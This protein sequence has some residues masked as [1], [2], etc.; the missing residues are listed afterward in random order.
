MKLLF[1]GGFKMNNTK[2]VFL[3]FYISQLIFLLYSVYFLISILGVVLLLW[4]MDPC[5]SIM[6]HGN[7]YI[8]YYG[9]QY[10]QNT[11]ELILFFVLCVGLPS[12]YNIA[13]KIIMLR[14]SRKVYKQTKKRVELNEFDNDSLITPCISKKIIRINK[15]IVVV[16]AVLTIV[17]HIVCTYNS[18]IF[19]FLNVSSLILTIPTIIG[20]L[21]FNHYIRKLDKF[22]SFDVSS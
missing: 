14:N 8:Y 12:L 9:L 22:T 17:F 10:Y 4:D 1:Q 7:E 20:I 18:Y 5:M 3:R 15:I 11:F 6:M 2:R 16:I 13:L 19:I 21:R